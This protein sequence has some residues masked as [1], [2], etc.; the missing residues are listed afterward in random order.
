MGP[1]G[2]DRFFFAG[3]LAGFFEAFATTTDRFAQFTSVAA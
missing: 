2:A 3:F 1:R